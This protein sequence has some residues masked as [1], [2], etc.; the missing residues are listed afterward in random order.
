[1]LWQHYSMV[2]KMVFCSTVQYRARMDGG[3]PELIGAA[4]A[5]RT[6][7]LV[8]ISFRWRPSNLISAASWS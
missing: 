4:A 1:M 8:P 2:E 6:V 3:P 5:S 7:L